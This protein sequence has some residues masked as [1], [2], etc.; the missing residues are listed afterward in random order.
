[1]LE[2]LRE[3]APN[4]VGLKISD[5]PFAA[6]QPYM[7]PGLDV[8]V[9]F[10]PLIPEALAAGAIGSVSG[11]AAIFP[12]AVVELVASP[13]DA[14]VRRVEELRAQVEPIL[15][16]GKAELARRGLMRTDV[17]APMAPAA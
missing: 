15:P 17:R 1:V 3:R 7:L 6:V 10:E 4:L 2:R 13:S 8:F 9:G 11:L 12:A 5:K 16:N 14:G